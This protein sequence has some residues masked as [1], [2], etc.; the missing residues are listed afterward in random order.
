MSGATGHIILP[1]LA[2][3]WTRWTTPDFQ[4]CL[5]CGTNPSNC[6]IVLYSTITAQLY[7]NWTKHIV[8]NIYST[9]YENNSVLVGTMGMVFFV[10]KEILWELFLTFGIF[11]AKACQTLFW[12]DRMKT[13]TWFLRIPVW[14]FD[15]FLLLPLVDLYLNLE[16]SS[17]TNWIFSL[18]K[19]I[20]KLMFAG[21][22]GSK[23]PVW[24]RLKI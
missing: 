16:K 2:L 19:S 17:W 11:W 6:P 9:K 22:T 8:C 13:S 7:Y 12:C 10:G 4:C 23:N 3:S 24:N 5:I 1:L 18:K 21:Y 15:I 20:S 14:Q